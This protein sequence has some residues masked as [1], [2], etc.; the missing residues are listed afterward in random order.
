MLYRYAAVVCMRVRSIVHIGTSSALCIEPGRSGR[1][2]KES[3]VCVCMR[4]CVCEPHCGAQYITRARKRERET[5]KPAE[6]NSGKGFRLYLDRFT[7]S[8]RSF[9]ATTGI[10]LCYG[11][12]GHARPAARVPRAVAAPRALWQL[13]ARTYRDCYSFIEY[14][15]EC[16]HARE[17]VYLSVACM[18]AFIFQRY[19]MLFFGKPSAETYQPYP[20]RGDHTVAR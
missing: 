5:R 14:S 18:L 7:G 16:L 17:Y 11:T 15:H 6:I 2:T 1:V 13:L 20:G 3:C 10:T 8:C 4:V 12:V 9:R 19:L